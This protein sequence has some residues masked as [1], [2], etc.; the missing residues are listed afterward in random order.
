M[1]TPTLQRPPAPP[2][3]EH[4]TD[5]YDG[6]AVLTITSVVT[7]A[8]LALAAYLLMLIVRDARPEDPP[9]APGIE[10]PAPDIRYGSE[11]PATWHVTGVARHER[12][13]VHAGPGAHE[14]VR[15]DVRG[16][17]TG[18]ASTGRIAWVDGAVWRELE[19]PG[20]AAGWVSG[21]Y[22]SSTQPPG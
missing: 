10:E 5:P 4:A 21:R 6:R 9:A 11:A 17:A 3:S 19:V 8:L 7:V 1:S 18:L 16:D 14:L 20:M 12:L 13:D 2:R 22:L 15:G